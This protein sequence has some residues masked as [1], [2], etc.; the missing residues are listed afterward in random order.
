VFLLIL[1]LLYHSRA[2]APPSAMNG[3]FM[4]AAPWPFQWRLDPHGPRG[5]I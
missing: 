1:H 2:A 3:E 5:P 4:S